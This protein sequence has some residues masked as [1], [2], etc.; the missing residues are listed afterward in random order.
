MEQTTGFRFP[1]RL[2]AA[3]AICWGLLV[4]ANWIPRNPVSPRQVAIALAAFA[5]I[6]P[7]PALAAWGDHLGRLALLALL[8]AAAA[9]AGAPVRR[10]LAGSGGPARGL[11]GIAV[12]SGAIGLGVLGAGFAGLL[13]RGPASLLVVAAALKA[14]PRVRLPGW[15]WA[16]A[17]DC[18]VLTAA[19]AIA[20]FLAL[21]GALA[22]EVSFDALAH[23][24]A[25]P[26]VWA[27]AHKVHA[28]PYHF[29]SLYPAMLEMQYLLAILLGGPAL[30]KLVH[31]GWGLVTIAALITWARRSLPDA[32]A[33][34]AAAGFALL[35]YVQTVM[36]WAYVDLG[37]SGY[38]TLAL[39]TACEG[40][41]AP[42]LLGVLC[43]L[44]A[45]TKAAGV[46]APVL[47]GAVLLGRRAGRRA[48]T[49]FVAAAFLTAAPW[50]VRNW[51]F[52]G[53]PVAPFLSG[54]FPVLWW[55]PG[56]Q[57]RYA[58]E[59]GSYE[60]GHAPVGGAIALLAHAWSASVRNF[61]VL[62][63]QAGMGAWFL[64]LI[65]LL[66]LFSVPAARLPAR[67]ALGFFVLWFLIPRQVRYLLPVWPAAALASAHALR[68]VAA[69][70][71]LALI[72]VWGAGLM[73]ALGVA[74]GFQREHWV[75]NPLP[76]VFGAETPD[77]YHARG[78]PG[79]QYTVRAA[80]WLR[81]H[82]A[83]GRTLVVSHYGLN[84]LWGPRAIAQSVFD[85]P[86]VQRAARE[87][88]G[89][90][91]I[92]VKIRQLGASRILYS[93]FGGF[94]MHAVYEMYSFDDGAAARWRAFWVARTALAASI[95]D[96]YHV[97]GIAAAPTGRATASV[98]PGLDEQWL[99]ATDWDLQY[100]EQTGTVATALPKAEAEYRSAAEKHGCGT[101]YER[102][103]SVLLR[104]GRMEEAGRAL[105]AAER[106]GRDTPVLHD[107]LGVVA[108]RDGRLAEAVRRFRRSLAIEPGLIDARRN[109]ASVLW[110]LEDRAAALGTLR[111]GLALDP[112]AGELNELWMRWTGTPPA[113]P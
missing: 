108:A 13:F 30:A 3:A 14:V 62:D 31:Y 32:W 74:G 44:C 38:L 12:G 80:E 85:T 36:M 6:Q 95:D 27:S 42:A 22:P 4:W 46:F 18:W 70:G 89:Q 90:S 43:G 91:R 52:A 66:S 10:W 23:H 69:R 81:L 68:A 45:G 76:V 97:Y 5:K 106:A 109:L 58:K 100:A 92:P 50:G 49:G 11:V 51:A 34:A 96:R 54:I 63:Q 1:T 33:L 53:S 19:I 65:P 37:A 111:E 112:G 88:A 86:L 20:L 28:L 82:P 75:I 26:S 110:N 99:G 93:T 107:A 48:W 104:E 60:L 77:A 78:L 9:G 73:L 79:K 8:A 16:F 15:R 2:V 56:N 47:V 94:T 41:A 113:A 59:L 21:L 55:D 87:A 84:L 39:M 71:G 17:A 101:A 25:H 83:A 103:G 57:A 72:P 67:L 35:P 102:L 61:G 7:G 64:W 24:L 29:L 98:L 40:A 105:L